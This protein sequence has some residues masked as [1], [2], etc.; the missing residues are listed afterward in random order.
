M[1]DIECQAVPED[2]SGSQSEKQ[3]N[4]AFEEAVGV[5]GNVATA[6]ELGYVHRGYVTAPK[7]YQSG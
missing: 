3:V 2:S 7:V 4:I 1:P 5:Y 6:E